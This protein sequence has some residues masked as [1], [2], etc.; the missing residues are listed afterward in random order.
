MKE[1]KGLKIIIGC[2]ITR[3]A[4]WLYLLIFYVIHDTVCLKN[5]QNPLSFFWDFVNGQHID[6]VV[7]CFVVIALAIASVLSTLY[8]SSV[9]NTKLKT[10]IIINNIISFSYLAI[11]LLYYPIVL[12]L[13]TTENLSLHYHAWLVN[14]DF[15]IDAYRGVSILL[16]F[17]TVILIKK[18]GIQDK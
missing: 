16:A 4:C 9:K 18:Y 17:I 2:S 14:A 6:G 8:L 12:S 1:K 3:I 5:K 11:Y 7:V 13:Y 15:I 10:L